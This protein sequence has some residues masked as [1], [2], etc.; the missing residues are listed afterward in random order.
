MLRCQS[1]AQADRAGH[2]ILNH[3]AR[4]FLEHVSKKKAER[5]LDKRTHVHA[6]PL[7]SLWLKPACPL[8]VRVVFV[9]MADWGIYVDE[10]CMGCSRHDQRHMLLA[11]R[12]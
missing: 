2:V 3:R 12:G 10:I 8:P 4:A 5:H 11:Q 1:R 9:L 7:S 6:A